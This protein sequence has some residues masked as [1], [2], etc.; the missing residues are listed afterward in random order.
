M[1][2]EDAVAPGAMGGVSPADVSSQAAVSEEASSLC[3]CQHRSHVPVHIAVPGWVGGRCTGMEKIRFLTFRTRASGWQG[4]AFRHVFV[5]LRVT[6]TQ[7]T[8]SGMTRR[9][10]KR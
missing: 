4:Q 9:R 6:G 5:G 7:S 10:K 8:L 2:R 1:W 3:D